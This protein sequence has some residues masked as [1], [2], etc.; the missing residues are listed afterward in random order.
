MNKF[1]TLLLILIILLLSYNA[2]CTTLLEL[3]KQNKALFSEVKIYT[4]KL[5]E[6]KDLLI[7]QKLENLADDPDSFDAKE[8]NQAI[9]DA[10]PIAKANGLDT[11][12][13]QKMFELSKKTILRSEFK[14]YDGD[15]VTATGKKFDEWM[16][17]VLIGE[18]KIARD[19]AKIQ[20]QKVELYR[21]VNI[22]FLKALIEKDPNKAYQNFRDYAKALQKIQSA[23]A[24]ILIA[25]AELL[26]AEQKLVTEAISTI[27]LVGDAL[28]IIS[29]VTAED[30][31]GEQLSSTQRAI[32]TLLLFT[33][34]I[35]EQVIKRNPSIVKS[36]GEISAQLIS[37][38]NSKIDALSDIIKNDKLKNM[39][40]TTFKRRDIDIW[41][42]QYSRKIR[43]QQKFAN[44]SASTKATLIE[45]SNK[46]LS[47][48]SKRGTA[49]FSTDAVLN[50]NTIGNIAQVSKS[51]N[52]II[53]TRPVNEHAQKWLDQ[54]ASTKD[55]FVKGK[56]ADAGLYAGLIPKK[57]KYSKLKSKTDIDS[58]QSKVDK[59]IESK[60]IKGDQYTSPLVNSKQ[61]SIKQDGVTFHAVELPKKGGDKYS[62]GMVVY[63]KDGKYFDADFNEINH[64]KLSK[65]NLKKEEPFEVLTDTKDNILT[66][67]L[68]LLSIGS[69]KKETIMQ[70]DA[71]MGNINSNEMETV[72]A[73][74]RATKN[75][76]F[77]DQRLSHHGGES[78]FI[79]RQSKPDF[80]LV[81]YSP[82]GEVI[83]KTEKQLKAYYHHQKLK[84]YNL[85]PNPFWK[86][87]EW[88]PKNGYK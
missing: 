46:K 86:W 49:D 11:V 65:Y 25:E 80:P 13:L 58:F 55:M 36:L 60:K 68:D 32:S 20:E 66:A 28:D 19:A 23:D 33:P 22:A 30:L 62:K 82:D 4:D 57:Q 2:N 26:V 8:I 52:E 84:G 85:E 42:E 6:D 71:I 3:D 81:A 16:D 72:N 10:M 70:N 78:S 45:K 15:T 1:S 37:M 88:N 38:K 41:R 17:W 9:K 53:I 40:Q 63:K 54:G 51:R 35:L 27:P 79:N 59:S 44:L 43:E 61:L 48:L 31:S 67:D 39:L 77:P 64:K 29:I 14:K 69:K 21:K 5:L 50:D 76:S 73:I 83:L 18:E 56:S 74:N 34:N 87:G 7:K 47:P 12:R 75:N 24:D